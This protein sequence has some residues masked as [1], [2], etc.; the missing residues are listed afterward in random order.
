MFIII[1]AI[2][3]LL[4]FEITLK[5]ISQSWTQWGTHSCSIFPLVVLHQK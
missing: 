2:R 5:Q 1:R 3:H 4:F